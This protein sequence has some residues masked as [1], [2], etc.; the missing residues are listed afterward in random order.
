MRIDYKLS[1]N[2]TV[3]SLSDMHVKDAFEHVLIEK[4]YLVDDY[5]YTYFFFPENKRQNN[6]RYSL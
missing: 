6:S 3:E 1:M 5:I 2:D 4:K